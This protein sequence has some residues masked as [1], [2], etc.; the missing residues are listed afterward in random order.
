MR[1]RGWWEGGKG[2][3]VRRVEAGEAWVWDER[4]RKSTR[5]REGDKN[6]KV[7]EKVKMKPKSLQSR[8]P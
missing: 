5:G 8:S 6:E 1:A 7:K 2:G 3:G 4:I